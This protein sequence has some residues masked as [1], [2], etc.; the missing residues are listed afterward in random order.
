MR[1]PFPG[2]DPYL[3]HPALWP[4]VHNSFVSALRDAITP[5]VAP[6]YYLALERRTYVLEGD[7]SDPRANADQPLRS[8]SGVVPVALPAID[9]VTD[10]FLE[11]HEVRSGT[12]VTVF[13]LLSPGNK[14]HKVGRADYLAKRA[15]IARSR[16][17][18]VEIDLLRDGAAMPLSRPAP[19]SDYRVL[20][21]RGASR[22]RADLHVFGVRDPLPVIP[23][24]LAPGDPE[25]QVDLNIVWHE[26]YERARFDLRIDYTLDPVPPLKAGDREWARGLLAR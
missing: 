26:L 2:T 21:S 11:V 22:P 19:D 25:P 12:L 15:K 14:L 5:L 16:T 3:E 1:S 17:N 13:E 10:T 7:A 18:L 6:R 9:E 4:D 23:I 20:I 24:P 8:G